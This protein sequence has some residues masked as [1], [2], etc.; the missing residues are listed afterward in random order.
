MMTKEDKVTEIQ[1]ISERFGRAKAAFL[2]DF[3]GLNVE[4]ST[5]LRM[6]LRQLQAEIRVVKN[7]LALR[8]LKEH[9]TFEAPLKD[10]F[11]GNNAVV[12][13][14]EDPSATAKALD[15]FLKVNEELVMKTG[16]MDGKQLNE[17][18][19]KYLA[20]LPGKP[21]LQAKLLGTL[22]APMG[23]LLGLFNNVPG[24]FVR[25]LAAYKDSKV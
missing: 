2:V 14:Y 3:K 1:S 17:A 22:Q 20:T 11:T 23:K 10:S 24:S 13:A 19:V 25:L 18:M 7:S 12:Y 15:A 21:E 6:Q 5:Q 8:A 9:A 4:K 16:A